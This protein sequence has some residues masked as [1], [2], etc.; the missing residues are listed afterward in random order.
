[1]RGLTVIEGLK[2]GDTGDQKGLIGEHSPESSAIY[3]MP[4]PLR[5]IIVGYVWTGSVRWMLV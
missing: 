2:I 5:E 1:M 3:T 4:E